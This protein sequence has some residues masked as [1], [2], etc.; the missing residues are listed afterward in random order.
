MIWKHNILKFIRSKIRTES[1]F[2][3]KNL[4]SNCHDATIGWVRASALCFGSGE[5]DFAR[6]TICPSFLL[7]HPGHPATVLTDTLKRRPLLPPQELLARLKYF[8]R[9]LLISKLTDTL[10]LQSVQRQYVRDFTVE[11]QPYD[12][13]II[14]DPKKGHHSTLRQPYLPLLWM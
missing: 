13:M 10:C 3:N 6:I 9:K 14:I 11:G 12:F 2:S 7:K 5:D 4:C 8:F 1:C